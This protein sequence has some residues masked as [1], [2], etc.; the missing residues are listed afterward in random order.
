MT[1]LGAMKKCLTILA[2]SLYLACL[3]ASGDDT[4][5]IMFW[6][7]ENFF[8]NRDGGKGDSDRE[9]SASGARHWTRRRML[10]KCSYICKAVLLTSDEYGDVPDIFA[11]AEV[12]NAYVLR[13]LIEETSLRKYGYRIVHYDSP[14]P[15]GIDVALL[16]RSSRLRLLSSRPVKVEAPGLKTRDI[17]SASF[18]TE[19]GDSLALLVN[20]H[21]SKYGGGDTDWRRDAALAALEAVT[22]SLSRCGYRSVIATGDFNDTPGNV[23]CAGAFPL[24]NLGDDPGF[25]GIGTIRYDGIWELIDM[26]LVS[27]SLAGNSRMSIVSIPFLMTWD[28]VHTGYKPL[29]TYSGPRYLGGVSDHCPVLLVIHGPE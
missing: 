20:H 24:V 23:R 11:V 14:D 17:L 15:R 7:L 8:D 4:L 1:F 3:P 29:R 6:N 26:F 2:L 13:C 16:Y 5:R 25:R 12:E 27:P 21:P 9:F 18:L 28:N 22:D 19:E 10:A